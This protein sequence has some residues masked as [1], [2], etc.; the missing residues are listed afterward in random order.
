VTD[1]GYTL[2]RALPMDF[3]TDAKAARISD[4]YMLG[5]AFLVSP[6]TT[7][8]TTSRQVYLPGDG[9]WVNFWTGKSEKGGQMTEVAA[10]LDTIPLFVR[11]GSIVPFGPDVQYATASPSDPIELRVYRGANGAFT[12]YDDEGDTYNYEKGDRALIPIAW[13]EAS[14]TL[15]IGKREGAYPGMRTERT[16]NIVWVA[17][18]RAVGDAPTAS[19]DAVVRYSGDAVRLSPKKE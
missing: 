2:M 16:F 8:N 15:T 17:Q 12:L 13:D 4:Q 3:P 6:V 10:P 19:F 1:K 7:P 9:Q 14:Q 5:P 11:A 18:G